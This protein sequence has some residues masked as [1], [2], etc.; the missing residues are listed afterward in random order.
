MKL[1]TII[2]KLTKSHDY[3]YFYKNVLLILTYGSE[4]WG[5]SVRKISKLF[6]ENNGHLF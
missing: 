2:A 3:T 6:I 4:I 5:H 1:Q